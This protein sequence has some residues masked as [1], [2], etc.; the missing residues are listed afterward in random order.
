MV[1]LGIYA[2][3]RVYW[4]LFDGT[5]SPDAAALRPLLI[6]IGVV[7]ALV[8]ATM[9]LRQRHLKRMLA[10]S[11]VSHIGLFL[12]CLGLLGARRRRRG[13]RLRPRARLRQGR[14]LH[15]RGD[16]PPPLRRGR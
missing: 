8:G 5:L 12:I 1:E 15:V 6:G 10:F 11:T 16:P 7:T 13:S 3:G 4:T 9:C 2:V 14:A